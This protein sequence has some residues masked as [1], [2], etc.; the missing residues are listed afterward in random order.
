MLAMTIVSNIAL[1]ILA[2]ILL[3]HIMTEINHRCGTH[4]THRDVLIVFLKIVALAGLVT[5]LVLTF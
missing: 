3:F 5:L 1:V 2:F 4:Y